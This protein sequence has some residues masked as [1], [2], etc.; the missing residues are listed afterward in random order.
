MALVLG[1]GEP[2]VTPIAYRTALLCAC[3]LT[4]AGCDTVSLD[5]PAPIVNAPLTVPAQ[6]AP[7]PAPAAAPASVPAA[8]ASALLGAP[9]IAVQPLA[10]ASAA[11]APASAPALAPAS[12]AS[13][14]AAAASA[15]LTAMAR[16]PQPPAS[17]PPAAGSAP[18]PPQAGASAPALPPGAAR[19][20]CGDRTSF[21]ASFGDVS[22]TL[23]T[24]LGRIQLEQ[25]V[26]ADGARYANG[27]LVVWFKGRE[28]TVNNLLQPGT[29]TLCVEQQ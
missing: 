6:P 11:S 16:P 22:V 28:A 20:V 18:L 15:P 1:P 26:A 25:T 12:A 29:S 14:A 10:P 23:Q 21:I 7:A 24:A 2:T 17:T 8:Q 13:A 9:S 19:Y 27:S 5:Q 3:A 4:L